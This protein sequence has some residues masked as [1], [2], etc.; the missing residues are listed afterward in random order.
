MFL[1]KFF[2]KCKAAPSGSNSQEG[3]S[4]EADGLSE[5]KGYSPKQQQPRGRVSLHGGGALGANG[6]SSAVTPPPP[7]PAPK[8]KFRI[9]L[10]TDNVELQPH[11]PEVSVYINDMYKWLHEAVPEMN[12][13]VD[14][15]LHVAFPDDTT[16][17]FEQITKDT[18]KDV[19][20]YTVPKTIQTYNEILYGLLTKDSRYLR[21]YNPNFLS[22]AAVTFEKTHFNVRFTIRD[23]P[24]GDAWTPASF[25]HVDVDVCPEKLQYHFQLFDMRFEI[26]KKQ[27]IQVLPK[28]APVPVPS[29]SDTE[30]CSFK[31]YGYSLSPYSSSS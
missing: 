3:G 15:G 14:E 31:V 20:V 16:V 6:S 18:K 8:R 30:E 2:G 29:K 19:L 4:S 13:K 10:A 27:V 28:A 23:T 11:I 22:I 1:L 26:R 5:S 9:E 17:R 7:Q 21:F 12:L 25:I 24:K